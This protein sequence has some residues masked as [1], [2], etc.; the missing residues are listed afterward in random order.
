MDVATMSLEDKLG[1]AV[2]RSAKYMP[3]ALAAEVAAIFTP[4][5][6]A[7]MAGTLVVWAGS[8]FAGVGFIADIIV[9]ILAVAFLGW[10]AFELAGILYDFATVLFDA[11]T[12]ADLEKAADLFAKAVLLAGVAVVSAVLLRGAA[13]SAR[14]SRPAAAPPPPETPPA[15]RR[16]WGDNFDITP[17]RP[18]RAAA[19]PA[20]ALTASA[21]EALRRPNTMLIRSVGGEWSAAGTNA[22]AGNSWWRAVPMELARDILRGLRSGNPGPTV[23]SSIARY[24]FRPGSPNTAE[25]WV[26]DLHTLVQRNPGANVV[27]DAIGDVV[28]TTPSPSQMLY[29]IRR[30]R[31]DRRN[32]VQSYYELF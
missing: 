29:G 2:R 32:P 20:S 3:E 30:F 10:T 13:K 23:E 26:T 31:F 16:N 12:E 25:V 8:H 5:N 24:G 19:A 22:T 4:I 11:K 21:Q 6:I 28:F 7:I 15:P 18:D 1:E 14:A 9:L 17:A 27:V